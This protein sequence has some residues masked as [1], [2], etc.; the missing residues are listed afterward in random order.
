[1]N[2]RVP[3]FKFEKSF[4]KLKTKNEGKTYRHHF[5]KVKMFVSSFIS[6]SYDFFASSD[7]FPLYF[8]WFDPFFLFFGSFAFSFS[9][10]FA[11]HFK[12]YDI[13]RKPKIYYISKKKIQIYSK[14]KSNFFKKKTYFFQISRK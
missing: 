4:F 10:F 1:M 5:L 11:N 6:N 2:L 14:S 3:D 13:Y 7:V 12:F 9:F 8:Q